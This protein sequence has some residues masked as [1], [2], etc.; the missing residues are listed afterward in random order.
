M[1]KD[2]R[3][4]IMT[5][6]INGPN[7]IYFGDKNFSFTRTLNFGEKDTDTYSIAI[8]DFDKNGWMDMVTGNYLKPNI[9]FLNLDGKTFEKIELSDEPSKTY[10]VTLGDINSDGWMDIAIA[11]SDDFNLYYL[12]IFHKN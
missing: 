8:A 1:D 2:G 12:N 9:V 4:D 6:N 10:G 5:G 3:L 7:T 11:N